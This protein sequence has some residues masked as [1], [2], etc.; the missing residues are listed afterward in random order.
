MA[1]IDPSGPNADQVAYWNGRNAEKWVAFQESMDH[2][3]A[4]LSAHV[5]DIAG[6]AIGQ[7]VVDIGC[8]CGGTSI[9]LAGRIG[10]SGAV[11]G[12]DISEPML[13]RARQRVAELS[14]HT[15]DFLQVDAS[16]HAF[17]G[18]A[19]QAFSRFGVM[20]FQDPAA[21]FRNIAG[22]LKPG[23][24]FTFVCWAEAAANP[25]RSVPIA[26]ADRHVDLPEPAAPGGP[27]PFSLSD[28]ER[29]RALLSEAGF[30]DIRI[31]RDE[32]GLLIGSTVDAAAE[33]AVQL[34]PL[35]NIMRDAPPAAQDAV[36]QDMRKTLAQYL[37]EDGVRLGA[38]TWIATARRPG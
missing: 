23:G 33:H 1:S 32:R 2:M 18:D 3:L 30:E 4:P 24:R 16:T 27:G 35:G 21:A 8:G 11:L 9:E 6:I 14:G 28:K 29:P 36:A 13:N 22:A 26:V 7:R 10:P 38:A 37:E 34:G 15:I 20:F 5:M 12:V 31:E 25:W 19:D 17:D